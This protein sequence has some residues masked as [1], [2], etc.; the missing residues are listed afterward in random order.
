MRKNLVLS[1]AL[2]GSLFGCAADRAY[3]DPVGSICFEKDGGCNGRSI[4][5]SSQDYTLAFVEIDEQGIFWNRNQMKELLD[6]VE[7]KKDQYIIVYVHGWH[8]SAAVGDSNIEG[9]QRRLKF[10]KERYPN[11]EVTGVYVGWRGDS[12]DV[13]GLNVLTFWDRKNVSEEIGKNALLELILR[14][15]NVKKHREDKNVLMLV[16][17]SFGGS[18]LFNAVHQ[19]LLQRL[20]QADGSD[21]RGVGD[22]VVLV[23]PAIESAAF[24]PLYDASQVHAATKGFQD[25]QSVRLIA[26][27]SSADNAAK[28][29]FPLGRSFSTALEKHRIYN[30]PVHREREKKVA[31][32]QAAMDVQAIGH[33][34]GHVTHKLDANKSAGTNYSCP[35]SPGWRK[36]AVDRKIA[37]DTSENVNLFG[38]GWDTGYHGRGSKFPPLLNDPSEMQVRHLVGKS[39][40]YSPYWIVATDETVFPGHNDINQKHF[41][42]FID[43][44]IQEGGGSFSPSLP[45]PTV[46]KEKEAM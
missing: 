19:T 6:H 35:Y 36:R 17:H 27:A 14:L 1:L 7:K 26:V 30:P 15:E 5:R 2:V 24:A 11:K 46:V 9:F 12:I 29:A 39:H 18:A 8:H 31:I 45:S 28:F 40:A 3:R 22:I 43:V 42:C 37:S 10:T 16:G 32:D 23:N 21:V 34:Y 38:E 13:S 4:I 25:T 33:F 41:W 20:I 44:V